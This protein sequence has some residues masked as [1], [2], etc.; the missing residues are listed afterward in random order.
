MQKRIP[1]SIETAKEAQMAVAGNILR[2]R[3]YKLNSMK[4]NIL[5]SNPQVASRRPPTLPTPNPEGSISIPRSNHVPWRNF[6]TDTKMQFINVRNVTLIGD[7]LSR[8]F[9]EDYVGP[10]YGP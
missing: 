3:K 9:S 1:L 10:E 2:E 4:P 7:P 8:R 6:I 5:I